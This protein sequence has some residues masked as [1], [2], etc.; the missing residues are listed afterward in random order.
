MVFQFGSDYIALVCALLAIACLSAW[1][2]FR[3]RTAML[4]VQ[5]AALS[6]LSMHYALVD[7]WTGA[8]VNLLGTIQIVTCLFLGDRHRWVGY[9]L[10]VL[11]VGASVA[12]WQGA[13]SALAAVGMALVA[14]GRAQTNAGTMR[15]IVLAGG[16]FWLAHDLLIRSPIAIADAAC[17]LIGLWVVMRQRTATPRALPPSA[18]SFPRA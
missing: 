14:I 6:W 13:V 1:P 15:L 5:L 9:A 7:A 12:T 10:A 16:P 4:L 3:S 17:L 2:L 11:M 18:S 8:A